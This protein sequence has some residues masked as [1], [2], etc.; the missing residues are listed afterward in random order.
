MAVRAVATDARDSTQL[1]IPRDDAERLRKSAEASSAL[2]QAQVI[3]V[4]DAPAAGT[5][6]AL[7]LWYW[8]GYAMAGPNTSNHAADVGPVAPFP[9]VAP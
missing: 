5:E 4:V 1:V 3:I 6:G 7:P 9:W 2:R 8:K